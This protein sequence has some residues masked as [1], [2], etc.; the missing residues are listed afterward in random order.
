MRKAKAIDRDAC[1]RSHRI[2]GAYLVLRTWK[3]RADCVVVGRRE[4][5]ACLG[6]GKV[7]E[8]RLR[9]LEE[10]IKDFFP[11]QKRS[12]SQ[13]PVRTAPVRTAVFISPAN[14]S[15]RAFSKTACRIVSA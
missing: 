11:Y 10:D 7:R 14:L 5:L 1:S 2:L 8:Q 4:S 15:R 13:A 6:V 3:R 12:N 9:W